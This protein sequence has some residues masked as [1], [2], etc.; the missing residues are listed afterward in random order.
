MYG[1]YFGLPAVLPIE[2]YGIVLP[3]DDAAFK[4]TVD[5]ALGALMK[6]GELERIY[7][8]WFLSPLPVLG[9]RLDLPMSNMLKEVVR[10]AGTR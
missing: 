6:E 5:V 2:P 7:E 8:R 4:Q 10:N 9:F 3:R 1:L